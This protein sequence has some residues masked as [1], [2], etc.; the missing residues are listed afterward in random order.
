MSTTLVPALH[1]LELDSKGS[2]DSEFMAEKKPA[3]AVPEIP[4]L[5]EQK[6]KFEHFSSFIKLKTQITQL[7]IYNRGCSMF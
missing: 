6:N 3:P 5:K 2:K 7:S 4:T 1:F